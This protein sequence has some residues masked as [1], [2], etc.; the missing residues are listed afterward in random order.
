MKIIDTIKH[1]P[2]YRRGFS[3]G[4]YCGFFLGVIF[5]MT[6]TLITIRSALP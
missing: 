6:I 4:L 2:L 1:Y 3:A 5:T